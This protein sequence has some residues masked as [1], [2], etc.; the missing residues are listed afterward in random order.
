MNWYLILK[1]LYTRGKITIERLENAII[2]GLI[3]E[4]EK[5]AIVAE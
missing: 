1:G 3:T 2:Q 5:Q 4:E